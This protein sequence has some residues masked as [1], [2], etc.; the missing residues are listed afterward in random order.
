MKKAYQLL[1]PGGILFLTIP[2][3]PDVVVFNLQ[4][5]Y[6]CIRLPLLLQGWEVIDKIGWIEDKLITEASWRKTYEPVFI[7]RKPMFFNNNDIYDEL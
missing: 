7:L 4:R 5:R 6:G 3:G 1:K 2:I